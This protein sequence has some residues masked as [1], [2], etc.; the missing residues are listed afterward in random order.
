MWKIILMYTIV[1]ILSNSIDYNIS[2]FQFY[3]MTSYTSPL[4][5]LLQLSITTT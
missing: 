1:Y 2:L 5:A 4:Y 3:Q